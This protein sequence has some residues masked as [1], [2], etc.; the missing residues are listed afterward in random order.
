MLVVNRINAIVLALL[1]GHLVACGQSGERSSRE[2]VEKEGGAQTPALLPK[3]PAVIDTPPASFTSKAFDPFAPERVSARYKKLPA[4]GLSGV[5]FPDAPLSSLTIVGFMTGKNAE[6][7]AMIR[8]G[9]EY[10]SV[11]QGNRISEQ[12]LLVKEI[13]A[14]G[15]TLSGDGVPDQQL[16]RRQ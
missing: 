11:R 10:R 1:T 5:L 4:T 14:Q 9:A 6:T 15:L 8:H 12:A 3:V 16:A 13:G 2:W 7:V